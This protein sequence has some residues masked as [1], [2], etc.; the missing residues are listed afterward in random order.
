M[1]G[2]L[3]NTSE[4]DGT[5][6]HDDVGKK[7]LAQREG[8]I[9]RIEAAVAKRGMVDVPPFCFN[10]RAISPEDATQIMKL[11][12]TQGVKD[13]GRI[14]TGNTHPP[15]RQVDT[16]YLDDYY[17][18]QLLKEIFNEANLQP[19]F[20]FEVGGIEV[21]H[22]C[23]YHGDSLGHYTWH[24]D[25]PNMGD[26][27]RVMSL[28]LLLNDSSEFEGGDL[29]FFIGIS[30]QGQPQITNAPLE[31]AGDVAVFKSDLLH[32]VRTVSK[33]TRVALVTWIWG[34]WGNKQYGSY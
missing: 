23:V 15:T 21:P 9:K 29:Q 26:Y 2:K 25:A 4:E 11:F 28:S 12:Y 8:D 31:Q 24:T 30:E 33:G 16:Y 1:S 14:A 5:V 22:M 18:H 34:E 3:Q 20:N 17:T 7:W 32:R 27:R 6:E 13:Q 10:Q 19:F